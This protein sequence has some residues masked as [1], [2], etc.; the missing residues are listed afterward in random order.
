MAVYAIRRIMQ[1]L[2]M[3]LVL[4]FLV[5]LGLELM[6]GDAVSYMVGPDAAASMDPAQLEALRQSLGLNDPL[7]VRYGS[8]LWG[9][10]QGDFGTSLTSG[11][12]VSAILAVKLAATL[13]LSFAALIISTVLG[14]TLG[15]LSALTR[16]SLLDNGLTVGGMLALSIPDFFFGLVLIV[17]F[18]LNLGWFPAGG[19]VSPGD[20]NWWDHMDH[21]LLP[22]LALGLA[23][24]A[25]V[26]R[27]SRSSMLD[28][29]SK[30]FMT[31]AKSKGMAPTRMN[32]VHGFRVALT[33]VMVLIGF[34][35]PTL[36]SGSVVIEQIFQW[37]GIGS[38]FL[39]AV[40][41]QDYPVIMAIALLSTTAVLLASLIVDLLTA[42]IDPRVRLS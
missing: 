20:V 9:L 1:I 12:D 33:P 35:L 19:R 5:F 22:A 11:N 23:M 38:E 13:E 29:Q 25:G 7:M 10:V 18:G 3:L 30:A 39:S 6:P 41:G 24:T 4:T 40:R 8:W 14:I 31:T 34:R 16:G 27:Y 26:M 15:I 21:L 17:T 28:V 37:P 42:V 36:I 32:I 2:P